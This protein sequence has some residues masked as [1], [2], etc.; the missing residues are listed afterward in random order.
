M[1][2]IVHAILLMVTQDPKK[3]LAEYA[4]TIYGLVTLI[5]TRIIATTSKG[6]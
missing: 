6:Q 2:D 3:K 5:K 1:S 4:V